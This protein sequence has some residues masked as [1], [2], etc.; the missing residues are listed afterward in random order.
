MC[1]VEENLEKELQHLRSI[2]VKSAYI[3]S[4]KMWLKM[5]KKKKGGRVFSNQSMSVS[6]F[7]E[8]CSGKHF[9]WHKEVKLSE[10]LKISVILQCSSTF[11]FI[12]ASEEAFSEPR[13]LLIPHSSIKLLKSQNIS[14][15][16]FM[17]HKYLCFI[18]KKYDFFFLIRSKFCP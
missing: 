9:K 7:P 3:K 2:W 14:V 5:D 12:I 11:F 6:V 18:H 17:Y 16:L 10:K 8:Q 1:I 4:D 13:S 15:H